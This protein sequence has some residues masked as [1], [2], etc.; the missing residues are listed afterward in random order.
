[1]EVLIPIGLALVL[2]WLLVVR[3]QRRAA[4]DH[5]KMVGSLSVDDEIVT[6]GGLY[7]R[8]VRMDG[9]VL[10]VEIAPETTVRIARGAIR[11]VTD[12]E[13]E[14]QAADTPDEP[15]DRYPSDR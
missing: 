9:D 3:P 4:A 15:D 1:M 10:T 12:P 7:G 6:A 11:G 8:I 2:I 14:E 13:E 5:V